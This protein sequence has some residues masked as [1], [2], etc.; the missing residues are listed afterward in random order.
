MSNIL[1]FKSLLNRVFDIKLRFINLEGPIKAICGNCLSIEDF[2]ENDPSSYTWE[3][4]PHH[5]GSDCVQS[6][7]FYKDLLE[8]KTAKT[9][10]ERA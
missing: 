8:D 5:P 6:L 3:A 2:D 4:F 1:M 7:K 9:G 10:S